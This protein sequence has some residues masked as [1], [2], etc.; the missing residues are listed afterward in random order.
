MGDQ[1]DLAEEE[2]RK[3]YPALWRRRDRLRNKKKPKT[4]PKPTRTQKATM[5]RKANH[6]EVERHGFRW[7]AEE[8]RYIR[9]HW[10]H[11]TLNMMVRD[12]GR[13]HRAI[14]ERAQLLDLKVERE[15]MSLSAFAK[16]SGFD[17]SK[18]QNAAEVLGLKLRRGKRVRKWKRSASRSTATS[19]KSNRWFVPIDI[20]DELLAFLLENA[21]KRIQVKRGRW[22]AGALP[23]RCEGCQTRSRPH[24]GKGHCRRC[25]DRLVRPKTTG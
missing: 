13:S 7:T 24:Y 22:G 2:F 21:E 5:T 15:D 8:D 12:L 25:Y 18:V 14:Y 10:G 16:Y 23:K 11:F 6:A 17:R 9:N 19:A 20:Q 1:H 3:R 4:K